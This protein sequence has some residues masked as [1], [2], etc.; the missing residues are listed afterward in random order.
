MS[1]VITKETKSQII[2]TI[3]EIKQLRGDLTNEE[4]IRRVSLYRSIEVAFHNDM[5]AY[6]CSGRL[7]CILKSNITIITDCIICAMRVPFEI[8]SSSEYLIEDA[9]K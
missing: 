3:A 5:L 1:K 4:V 2:R 6:T 7:I 9:I 8:I